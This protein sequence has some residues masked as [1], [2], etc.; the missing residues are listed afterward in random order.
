GSPKLVDVGVVFEPNQI[1]S[2]FAAFDPTRTKEADILAGV[3]PLG[4]LADEEQRKKLYE[5]MPSL[6]GQ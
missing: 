3:L 4:L 6:L 5:L 1:R 2:K